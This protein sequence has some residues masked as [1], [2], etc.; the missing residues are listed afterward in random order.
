MRGPAMALPLILGVLCSCGSYR[1]EEGP[2][3]WSR[4]RWSRDYAEAQE[5][6]LQE[7]K[8]ILV[9]LVSGDLEADC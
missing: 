2:G 1:P 5:R 4:I 9:I 8:P 6:A 7:K 3:N